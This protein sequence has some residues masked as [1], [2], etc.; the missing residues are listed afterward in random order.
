M[1]LTENLKFLILTTDP[2][3]LDTFLFIFIG[4]SLEFGV[5]LLQNLDFFEVAWQKISLDCVDTFIWY[6]FVHSS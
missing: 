5:N 4:I 2:Q 3:V 1:F 6:F